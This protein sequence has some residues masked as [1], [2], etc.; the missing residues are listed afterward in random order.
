M[1]YEDVED[2]LEKSMLAGL[3]FEKHR[4]QIQVYME[5]TF[6]VYLDLL[7]KDLN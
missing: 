1:P 2:S 6:I 7:L 4:K 5:Q 3:Q